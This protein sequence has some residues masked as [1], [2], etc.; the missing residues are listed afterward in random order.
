[1]RLLG[2][3]HSVPEFIYVIVVV[4]VTPAICEEFFFR[5]L[6]Q[7]NLTLASN[8]RKGLIATGLIFGLYH[9]NP[10]LLVPLSI[11][12]IFFSYVRVRSNTLILP[13]IAHFANNA[14]STAGFFLQQ[15]RPADSF[16][17]EGASTDVSIEYVLGVTGIS[18]VVFVIC[19]ISYRIVTQDVDAFHE[20]IA[21]TDANHI[22][23]EPPQ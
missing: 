2:E 11:L 8:A 17:L 5:G 13:V 15:Q 19:L 22:H 1:M 7:K 14:V 12:G 21:L 18:I 9:L 16:L 23:L 4:A 10:F 20:G 3:A 6:I